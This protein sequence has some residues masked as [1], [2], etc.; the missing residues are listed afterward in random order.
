MAMI[1]KPAVPVQITRPE[2][3]K[4]QSV[5]QDG[6]IETLGSPTF[7]DFKNM[8]AKW[9]SATMQWELPNGTTMD[10]H[11]SSSNIADNIPVTEE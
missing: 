3:I 8:V 9:N 6:A 4:V 1:P 2:E 5:D 7:S 11:V 10:C